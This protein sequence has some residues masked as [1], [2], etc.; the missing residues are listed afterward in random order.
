MHNLQLAPW[1]PGAQALA[2]IDRAKTVFFS[3]VSYEFGT[4][5]T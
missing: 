2:E 1:S 5:L 4:P 3:H